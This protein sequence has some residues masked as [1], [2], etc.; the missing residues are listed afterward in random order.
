MVQLHTA[1]L[2]TPDNVRLER[3][4]MFFFYVCSSCSRFVVTCRMM[5]ACESCWS[6]WR[7]NKR[8]LLIVAFYMK[9]FPPTHLR[10]ERSFNAENDFFCHKNSQTHVR[11]VSCRG[12]RGCEK[13]FNVRCGVA[14]GRREANN[15]PKKQT[16]PDPLF[17][18]LQL[19]LSQLS[20][21]LPLQFAIVTVTPRKSIATAA[22]TENE[23]E[24]KFHW[25]R[26][27]RFLFGKQILERE[28]KPS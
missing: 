2:V 27:V 22:D 18:S 8:K 15:V 14:R 12:R 16:F 1:R 9:Q 20:F 13:H 21:F 17:I 28:L 5:K 7:N 10:E 3:F 26:S 4:K 6:C 25:L 23:R 11:H 19:A 24:K